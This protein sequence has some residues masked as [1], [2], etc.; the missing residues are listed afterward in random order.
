M[1][2]YKII[3]SGRKSFCIEIKSGGEILV[4]MPYYATDEDAKKFVDSHSKWI[5]KSVLKMRKNEEKSRDF[6][7]NELQK[8]KNDAKLY[9]PQRVRELAAQ[10]GLTPAGIKI[11]SARTRFGSCS[12]KNSLCFSFYLM[13]YEKSA[14]DY[15]IIH[16]L[17]HT[18]HHNHGKKFWELVEKLMPDYK[19]KQAILKSPPDWHITP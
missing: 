6:T 16:E 18:V 8:L 4:R 3:R 19:E 10:T 7:Q 13:Q 9:I 15:V 1:T 12:P 17:A 14:I 5:E 2:G 11:T